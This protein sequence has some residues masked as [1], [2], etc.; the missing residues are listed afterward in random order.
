MIGKLKER[1]EDAK[2][3]WR[4]LDA[5]IKHVNLDWI[6]ASEGEKFVEVMTEF[7]YKVKGLYMS[8]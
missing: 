3:L 8:P 7:V 1:K 5:D 4:M 6:S 2:D